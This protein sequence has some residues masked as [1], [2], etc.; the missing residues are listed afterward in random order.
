MLRKLVLGL[1]IALVC[2]VGVLVFNTLRLSSKQA[3]ASPEVLLTTGDSSVSRFQQ[4]IRFKTIS[5]G[6]GTPP[7]SAQFLGFRRFLEK[8]YPLVHAKLQREVVNQYSLLYHWQ[9][10]SPNLKPVILMAHQDVVPVEE[11]S[12]AKW[13]VD[14]FAGTLK[15]GKI[16]GRGSIDDK[17][18]LI[19]ILEATERL[20]S[21]GHQPQRSVYLVFGHDEEASGSQGAAQVAALLQARGVEAEFVLDEGGIITRQKIPGLENRPV[22]LIGTA[23]KGYLSVELTVEIPGGHSS[24]PEPEV[25]ID[26]LNRALI[27]IRE[28]PFPARFSPTVEDFFAYL[29][30]EMPFVQRMAIA[31]R[32]LFKGLLVGIYEKSAAGNATVRTTA[33]PTILNSGMKDNVVPTVARAIV[34]C[35]MLPGDSS[36]QV[37]AYL[38]KSID[39][40][41][42]KVIA[43]EP[44]FEA[45]G[46]TS[47][48]SKGY[49]LVEKQIR[50]NREGVLTSPFMMI[51]ATDSR[52]FS[53]IS[54]HILKFSPMEDPVGFHGINEHIGVD[55]YQRSISFYYYLLK[56]LD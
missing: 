45:S 16:W 11:A 12:L 8:N 52:Y 32:W 6:E 31:N 39:D 27:R 15:D 48:Q 7:D 26:V 10:T 33:V 14:P 56:E 38:K 46:V 18:N 9:G 19:S 49:Q 25:A 1:V 47:T 2:L 55:S 54:P 5:F 21:E 37:L 4:S 20:L 13:T 35:R 22:A 3:L 44:V 23:E 53:K 51:G 17:I 36:E 28:N 40:S 42:V 29:G 34:N 24:M 30:P 43:L 50:R 41:R